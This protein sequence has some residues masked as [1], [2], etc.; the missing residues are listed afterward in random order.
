MTIKIFDEIT[1]KFPLKYY[2]IEDGKA[3]V[4][5]TGRLYIGNEFLRGELKVYAFSVD[6]SDYITD[7]DS[8]AFR[9]V[10]LTVTIE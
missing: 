7:E 2:N 5:E 9:E 4:S 1:N 3:Y 8:M 6:G 10:N